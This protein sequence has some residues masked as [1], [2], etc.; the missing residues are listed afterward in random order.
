METQRAKAF[1]LSV[2]R[3]GLRRKMGKDKVMGLLKYTL[4]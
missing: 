1:D 4:L 2:R 3:R